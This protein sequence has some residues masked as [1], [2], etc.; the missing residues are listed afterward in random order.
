MTEVVAE[1]RGKAGVIT[2][3]RPQAL[4]ALNQNMVELLDQ[5]LREFATNDDI[6]LV[7]LRGAGERGLCAGGDI[8]ALYNDAKNNGIA[9]AKFWHDEYQLNHYISEYPKP[10]VAIMN[11]IVLGGGI[12]VSGH[13]SHRIVTDD[14]R[15]GMPETGIGFVP[16]VGGTYLLSH[17][18]ANL[19]VHLGLTGAHVGAAEAIATGLADFY[20]ETSKLE[21]LVQQLCDTGDVSVID[22]F[23]SVMEP[24]FAGAVDEISV[25]YEGSCVEDILEQLDAVASSWAA[26]AATKIRR[27]SPLAVKVT[28][29][30]IQRARG[31]SLAEALETE[32]LVSN[33]MHR[34][35][36]FREGV[37]AQ[38]VDKD[39]NPRWSP[40]TL[41]EV[42]QE[43]VEKIFAPLTD[44][45]I[46][47]LNLTEKEKHS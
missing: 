10:Y 18:P 25:A 5:A 7:I 44:T 17:A 26:E 24:A 46:T 2:L 28:L 42:T 32:Y 3:N 20:V 39:R 21:P 36:D 6:T 31:K 41:S 33:N 9:G 40:S 37:R 34:S 4:N 14:T 12:G 15:L 1:V 19:G 38:V 16:D 23:T 27:N 35:A 11:G 13:G 22:D 29:E 45:R 47:P 43:D 8:V 30:S